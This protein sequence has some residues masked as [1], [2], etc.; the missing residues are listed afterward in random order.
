VNPAEGDN[1][2]IRA[3]DARLDRGPNGDVLLTTDGRTLP[4]ARMTAA[5]PLSRRNRLISLRDA[6]GEEIGMLDNARDLDGRSR[7]IVSEE[8]ERAYFMPKITDISGIRE[9]M[10][11]L[12][13]TVLTDKGPRTFLVRGV[14]RNVRRI[15]Q[16]RYMV[17]DVD[18]NRYE[19]RDWMRLPGG[20][21]KLLEPYV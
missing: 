15:G 7:G 4:V 5:Y 11:V 19:V 3:R 13:W 20:A 6:E 17:K 9:E 16:R 1:F 10:N 12:E 21:R 18:G 8:L 2:V 14:R